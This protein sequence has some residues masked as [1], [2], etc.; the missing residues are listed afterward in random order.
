MTY[1]PLILLLALPVSTYAAEQPT[2]PP[3][4]QAMINAQ[5]KDG[6]RIN[7]AL[8]ALATS[9]DVGA[10]L[11]AAERQLGMM[12]DPGSTKGAMAWIDKSR[13]AYLAGD[14]DASKR[15]E[16]KAIKSLNKAQLLINEAQLK[17]MLQ[18]ALDQAM[19]ACGGR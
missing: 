16:N 6:K 11:D 7:K 12:Q 14:Y 18:N 8:I 13:A 15:F 10:K 2:L 4:V 9:D 3:E 5:P 17:D 1:Y 19:Q